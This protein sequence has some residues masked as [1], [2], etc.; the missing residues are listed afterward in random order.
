MSLP[1]LK[2]YHKAPYA[3]ISPTRPESSQTGRTVLITGGNSGIGYAIARS[4]IM[5]SVRHVIITGRRPDIVQSAAENLAKESKSL[6]QETVVTGHVCDSASVEQVGALWE[7][8]QN[9]RVFVD[10]L[11]L[12]AAAAGQRKAILH[13]GLGNVWADFEMN[14]RGHL[15]FAERFYKQTGKGA[16]KQKVSYISTSVRPTNET[17]I[18]LLQHLVNVSSCATYM[19]STVAPERPSYGLTKNCGT[20]LL[21]QIAKDV[22]P[23]DMQVVSYHPG[24]IYTEMARKAGYDDS[25]SY[26][27]GQSRPPA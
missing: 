15:D 14:V 10:V 19:W 12:N 5:A 6:A 13:N 27:N 11:V 2:K 16:S 22:A 24:G 20:L 17:D 3:A 23:D 18:A 1:G 21:Q 8:L 4:F 26:D 7:A 9:E 25:L